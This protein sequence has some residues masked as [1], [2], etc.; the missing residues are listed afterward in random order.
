M[1]A[2][3]PTM[4]CVAGMLTFGVAALAQTAGQSTPQTPAGAG[5][6]SDQQITLTGCV[7]KEADYR[8]AKDSG[9][10]GVAGTGVGAGNEFILTDASP[11]GAKAGARTGETTSPTGTV[12]ASTSGSTAYELTGPNEGQVSQYVGKRVEIT[13]KLKA[14]E[15][16]AAGRPTGGATAGPPPAG[17][18][19]ASKDL[20][21][22]ELE[23]SS[24]RESTG[25]CT[26]VK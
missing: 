13:G 24:V 25:T 3:W 5:S 21:L 18:D 10:G 9:K 22:R 12:G 6:A 26:P 7:Q 14:A 2:K 17:V 20:K 23:V 15:T 11:S 16:T 4:M 19:V 8:K 1:T